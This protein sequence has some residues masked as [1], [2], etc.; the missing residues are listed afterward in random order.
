MC[1]KYKVVL[2]CFPGLEIRVP[3]KE[4]CGGGGGGGTAGFRRQLKNRFLNK[5]FS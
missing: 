3:V 1:A 2:F 5:N 4:L